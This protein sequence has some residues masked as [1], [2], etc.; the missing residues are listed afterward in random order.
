MKTTSLPS[1]RGFTL[2]ESLVT[3]SIVGIL[4]SM[5]IPAVQ[6]SRRA[7]QRLACVNQL[8]Q[9]ELATQAYVGT[10]NVFP[11]YFYSGS[12][13][14]GQRSHDFSVMSR[15]LPFLEQRQI[16]NQINFEVTFLDLV[17]VYAGDLRFPPFGSDANDTV[18][19]IPVASFFCPA[20][21]AS[22]VGKLSAG[23]NYQ[24]NFGIY[25]NHG[26][27]TRFS[28]PFTYWSPITQADVTDGLSFTASFSEKPRGELGRV[29]YDPFVDSLVAPQNVNSDPST[30]LKYC[31]WQPLIP[32][33]YRTSLRTNWLV[34]GLTQTCY[35]HMD[36]PNGKLPDCMRHS[37]EP[38]GARSTARSYHSVGVNVAMADGSVHHVSNTINLQTWQALGTRG[39]GELIHD[40]DW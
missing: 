30:V 12:P 28:G 5:I 31:A 37:A 10:F 39:G 11:A 17:S 4:L 19:K 18:M 21:P 15:I 26:S 27:D 8:K 16:Y 40:Q 7:A 3:F 36:V 33:N 2:L 32:K 13:L 24:A 6:S 14:P 35:N 9:L 23:S 1:R 20:D 38:S 25:P 34:G 22:L 29:A